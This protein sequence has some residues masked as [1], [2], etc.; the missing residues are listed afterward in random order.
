MIRP[1]PRRRALAVAAALLWPLLTPPAEAQASPRPQLYVLENVRLQADDDAPRVKLVL[2]G[3]R[4]ER[5]LEASAGNPPGARSIDGKGGFVVPAFI[6]AFTRAGCETPQPAAER[7]QPVPTKSDVRIDMREANRKGVQPSFR[8]VDVFALE[9]KEAEKIRAAGFGVLLSAPTGN[10]L[11]GQSAVATVR[12]AAPRDTVV[13]SSAFDHA[14]FRAPGGGYPGTLMGYM[15]QLRQ[16]FL[17]ARR[18][19]E[20]RDR[21]AAGRPGERPPFDADLEAILPALGGERRVVCQAQ[22]HRDIE[23]WI[24]LADEAGLEI[25]ISGGRDA[26]RVADTLAQ[27]GIPVILTLDWGEEVVDPHE[28]EKKSK[29]KKK[30]AE[31]EEAEAVEEQ[32]PAGEPGEEGA[33]EE[34]EAEESDWEYT[35]PLAVREERR[36]L[37]EEK[38]DCAIRLHEAG[39]RFAFGSDGDSSKDLLKRVREVVEAGLPADAALAALTSEAAGLLGVGDHVGSVAPGKD[40]TLAVWTEHPTAK[41]AKLAWLFVDGFPYE[42]ELEDLGTGEPDE[43]VDGTGTWTIEMEQRGETR[44]STALLKMTPEGEVTGTMSRENPA[45]EGDLVT[46]VEGH[47]SGVTMTLK[48]TYE[49]RDMEITFTMKGDLEEDSWSGTTTTKGPFGEFESSFRATREPKRRA[50]RELKGGAQ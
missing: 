45:G 4:V 25:A 8:A 32:A 37:W 40:A 42:F 34:A 44:T 27:R 39:V 36:R 6:D 31:P 9:D 20:L 19:R 3:G 26:W 28:K 33:E 1:A 23:R 46:D 17:D 22:S 38:R 43:G 50:S 18:H 11:A 7:D 16:F 30:E 47:V 10:L 41:D 13:V 14:A 35:E 24:K 49:I 12:D 21:Y 48:G 2:S 15:S 29:G 5:V